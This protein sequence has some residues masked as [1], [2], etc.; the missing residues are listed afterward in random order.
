MINK[1]TMPKRNKN[2]KKI[3]SILVTHTVHSHSHTHTD[4]DKVPSLPF[5]SQSSLFHLRL[6]GKNRPH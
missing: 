3:A 6:E 2:K 5:L 4:K 1:Q